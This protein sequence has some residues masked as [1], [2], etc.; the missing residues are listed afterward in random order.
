MKRKLFCFLILVSI[1]SVC[2]AKVDYGKPAYKIINSY[3]NDLKIFKGLNLIG[4]G[5]SWTAEINT[6]SLHYWFFKPLDLSAVRIL[7][8]GC[9]EDLISRIN[10]NK[11]IRPYLRD[12]PVTSKNIHIMIGILDKKS[13]TNFVGKIALV[14]YAKGNI[15]YCTSNPATGQLED[16]HE[17]RY[18]EALRIV[19]EEDQKR[20]YSA[21]GQE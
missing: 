9:V 6:I 10:Q 8:I 3:S 15:Y 20:Y 2:N 1:L 12:F 14:S 5:G 21:V 11:E 17:E 19:R 4:S 16:F 13:L 18:E 7:Y